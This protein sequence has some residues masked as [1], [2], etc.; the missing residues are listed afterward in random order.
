LQSGLA[1]GLILPI[2]CLAKEVVSHVKQIEKI[3]KKEARRRA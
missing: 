3:P 1:E 2:Y